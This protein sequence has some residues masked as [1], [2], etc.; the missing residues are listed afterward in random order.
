MKRPDLLIVGCGRIGRLAARMLRPAWKVHF[1]ERSSRTTLPRGTVRVRGADIGR[2]DVVLFAIPARRLNTFLVRYG[3]S[4]KP[5]SF[6]A[7]FCAVK[8]A[9]MRW[10]KDSLP[11]SVSF[12]GLHPL[13]GPESLGAGLPVR[14]I[15]V[16]RGRSSDRCHHRLLAGLR[17]LGLKPVECSPTTHD[18]TM[19]RTLYLAQIIGVALRRSGDPDH[20]L[21]TPTF[22]HLR[23]VAARAGAN[24]PSLLEELRLHNRF[25]RGALSPLTRHLS[26]E[27]GRIRRRDR[28]IDNS[29]EKPD[30]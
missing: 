27:A 24:G 9:P 6:V 18:R 22:D 30:T 21:P 12:A 11:P 23:I 7:D 3:S 5:G 25:C 16:C 10:M 26:R 28:G 20:G 4:L 8:E 13:F 19:A 2:F 17:S 15:A 1:L 14:R 29:P